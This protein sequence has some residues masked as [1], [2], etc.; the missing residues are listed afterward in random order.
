[1][2][3]VVL[4]SEFEQMQKDLD[5]VKSKYSEDIRRQLILYLT[6]RMKLV[7]ETKVY[8]HYIT[9]P[10]L[11]KPDE[12]AEMVQDLR[13]GFDEWERSYFESICRIRFSGDEQAKDVDPVVF[14]K[15]MVVLIKGL[16]LQFF[17]FDDY[18]TMRATYESLVELLVPANAAMDRKEFGK[19]LMNT[20]V[21]E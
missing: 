20:E 8:R 15:M 9:S 19:D 16:E 12:V 14:G 18:E 21:I 7:R 4:Q 6:L 17:R 5:K 13:N 2:L 3:K 11:E 1:M 10:Y